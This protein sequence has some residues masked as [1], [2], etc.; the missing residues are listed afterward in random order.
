MARRHPWRRWAPPSCAAVAA[1]LLIVAA[2]P[3]PGRAATADAGK[4]KAAPCETCHGATGISA[5]QLAPNLAGQ[6]QAY[7]AKAL[8]E[9][10]DGRRSNA[11]MRS[12]ASKLSDSDI[13][14]LAAYFSRLPAR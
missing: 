14:D 5:S 13:S 3:P 9:Y 7:L 6:K 11:M 10:R 2:Y 12:V 4:A 8:E 1:A